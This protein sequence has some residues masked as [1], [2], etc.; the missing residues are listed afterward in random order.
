MNEKGTRVTPNQNA[1]ALRLLVVSHSAAMRGGAEKSLLDLLKQLHARGNIEMT[2]LFPEADGPLVEAVRQ[3]GIRCESARFYRQCYAASGY[4]PIK[5]A[6][7]YVKKALDYWAAI[8]LAGQFKGKFDLVY[9]NTRVVFLGVYLAKL[10]GLPHVWHIREFGKEFGLRFAF[11]HD[12]RMG[13]MADRFIATS[14]AVADALP[15]SIGERKVRVIYNGIPLT[16]NVERIRH[17]GLNLIIC[18]SIQPFKHQLDAVKALHLVQEEGHDNVRLHIV[19]DAAPG[20]EPYL[21]EI[22]TYVSDHAMQDC[23]I[24]HGYEPD[25]PSVRAGMDVELICSESEG[26][27]RVSIEAMRAGLVVVAANCGAI[28]EIIQDGVDGLMYTPGD[29]ADLVDKIRRTIHPET[30]Q[31]LSEKAVMNTISRFLPEDNAEQVLTVMRDA[32]AERKGA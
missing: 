3:A 11:G 26:F 19:G 17:D 21:Q 20:C 10:L 2:V 15:A 22:E 6:K 12:R 7:L 4:K 8:R 28:P 32:L 31:A 16:R 18:G 30:R 13:R 9:S 29:V 27:G 24:F 23:V 25:M 1:S 14:K 5:D